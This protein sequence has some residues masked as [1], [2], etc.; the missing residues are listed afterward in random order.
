MILPDG[1]AVDEPERPLL[2]DIRQVVR[3]EIQKALAQKE[4]RELKEALQQQK[5]SR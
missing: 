1:I 5:K 2:D 4:I 3:E